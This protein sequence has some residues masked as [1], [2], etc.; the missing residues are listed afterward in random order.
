M[1]LLGYEY[2]DNEELT[3]LEAT[4]LDEAKQR[5]IEHL[6]E[7]HGGEGYGMPPGQLPDKEYISE[8]Y[9]YEYSN[10]EKLDL[11]EY[12]KQWKASQDKED[13]QKAEAQ[14][15]SEYERLKIKYA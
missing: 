9:I 14:E 2:E 13:Q 8:A 12:R 6:V 3:E 1:F 11:D 5:A 4:N 7:W 10:K 15:R